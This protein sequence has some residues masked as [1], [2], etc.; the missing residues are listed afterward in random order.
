MHWLY[1][2]RQ[3][4]IMFCF[5]FRKIRF[6]LKAPLNTTL[7]FTLRLFPLCMW[8]NIFVANMQTFRNYGGEK[9][10]TYIRCVCVCVWVSKREKLSWS[11][12]ENRFIN[13][14]MKIDTISV[15]I[16]RNGISPML[17]W[18]YIIFIVAS[19]SLLV[20]KIKGLQQWPLMKT[21]NIANSPTNI[22]CSWSLY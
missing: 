8:R 22:L 19:F 21:K 20:L 12:N 18:N 10:Y 17:E 14:Q 13:V 11:S 1:I 2:T 3:R 6:S 4:H 16:H 15:K 7:S 9:M 5:P